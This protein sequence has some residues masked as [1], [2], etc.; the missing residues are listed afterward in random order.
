[1]VMRP[2]A[3]V[4][5]FDAGVTLTEAQPRMKR[6]WRWLAIV[7]TVLVVGGVTLAFINSSR[8]QKWRNPPVLVVPA[9]EVVV[10]VRASLR[11]SQIGFEM[12]PEFVVPPEHVPIILAWIRPAKYIRNPWELQFLDEL[13]EVVIGTKNGRE[14]RMRFYEA[15]KNPAVI[16]AG[17]EDQFYGRGIDDEGRSCDGG[18]GL[19]IAIRDAYA[20]FKR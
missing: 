14:L 17:N 16:T 8:F 11:A 15:G 9:D 6:R 20:A 7:V 18:I 3:K 19:G 1:M 12:I 4:R 2:L 5:T 10:E 13:G